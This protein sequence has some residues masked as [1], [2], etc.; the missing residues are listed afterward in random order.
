MVKRVAYDVKVRGTNNERRNSGRRE[1][2]VNLKCTIIRLNQ[3]VFPG[4]SLSLSLS[5]SA[6]RF[7]TPRFAIL[8]VFISTPSSLLTAGGGGR[9]HVLFLH[10]QVL[11]FFHQQLQKQFF[12]IASSRMLPHTLYKV[13]MSQIMCIHLSIFLLYNQQQ[14]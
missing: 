8:N 10:F 6:K 13:L 1:S 7:C 4:V 3:S 9:R 2:F 11:L 14:Q 5:L 12:L